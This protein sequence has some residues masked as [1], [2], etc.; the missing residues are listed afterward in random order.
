MSRGV[1][2]QLKILQ[3]LSLI[4]ISPAVH[5]Q[6]LAN[7]RAVLQFHFRAVHPSVAL[8]PLLLYLVLTDD[9]CHIYPCGTT[10]VLLCFK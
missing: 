10:G 2:T 7:V 5:C 6:L 8:T 3:T 4:A 9:E 1:D